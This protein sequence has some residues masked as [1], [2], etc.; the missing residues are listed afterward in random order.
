MYCYVKKS[1]NHVS[2]TNT[3]EIRNAA[4]ELFCVDS[5]SKFCYSSRHGYA[6]WNLHHVAEQSVTAK[7][8]GLAKTA[9]CFTSVMKYGD[10]RQTYLEMLTNSLIPSTFESLM[11]LI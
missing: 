8:T 1:E 7:I 11:L 2:V 10:D 5:S 3:A 4:Y 6:T 9:P